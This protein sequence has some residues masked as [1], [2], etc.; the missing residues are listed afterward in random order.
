[1]H[2]KAQQIMTVLVLAMF[3]T[4]GVLATEPSLEETAT[5]RPMEERLLIMGSGDINGTYYPVVGAIC[6]LINKDQDKHGLRCLVDAGGG[7]AV[8]LEGLRK[9]NLDLAIVQSLAQDQV[10]KG[11][12][13]FK[14]LGAFPELRSLMSLHGETTIVISA[15]DAPIR[16]IKDLSGKRVNLGHP[17]SFQRTMADLVIGAFGWT[18]KSFSH[19][20]EIEPGNLAKA[21]CDGQLD[22]AFLTGAQPSQEVDVMVK[23]CGARILDINGAE[24]E[25][26]L[27]T[28]SYLTAQIIP[29]ML[30]GNDIESIGVVATLTTTTEMPED[31]AYQTV[32]AVM[33]NFTSLTEM[34]I[35]LLSLKQE[36]MASAGLSAPLHD[37]ARRYFEENA[38]LPQDE[39][40]AES[41]QAQ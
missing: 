30:Y 36:K 17:G 18:E 29:A 32:K 26:L 11:E 22:A 21:M 9:G 3:A 2:R 8:N 33:E 20:L 31:I 10:F 16:T 35:A 19:A 13:A 25:T 40:Q 1:M 6:R 24:I 12:G 28:H 34:H 4:S 38:T 7:S 23:D 27:T 39:A 15:K 41:K 14:E 37:G 5:S